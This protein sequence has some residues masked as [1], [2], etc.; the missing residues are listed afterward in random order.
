M[1]EGLTD[2]TDA[3]FEEEVIKS[4]IPVLVDFWAEWCGPCKQ[5]TPILAELAKDNAGKLKIC[6]VDVDP[7]QGTASKYAI[8]NI[9]T[10]LLFKNGEIVQQMVGVKPK[11]KIQE[12]IDKVL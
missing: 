7:N 12:D 6:K 3:S 2:V 8:R 10:M 5:L 4:D 9:P 1:A 11:G